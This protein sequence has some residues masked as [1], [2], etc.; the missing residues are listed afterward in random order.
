ME[1]NLARQP[2]LVAIFTLLLLIVVASLCSGSVFESAV[3]PS[4]LGC[5]VDNFQATYPTLSRVFSAAALFVTGLLV[6][7]LT[8]KYGLYAAGSCLAIPL[9]G[10]FVCGLDFG[11]IPLTVCVASL[12]LARSAKNYYSGFRTGNYGFDGFFRASF[13]LGLIPLLYAPALPLMLILPLAIVV[14]KRA[15]REFIVAI[16][17]LLLPLLAVCY[18]TWGFGGSF[19]APLETLLHAFLQQNGSSIFAALAPMSWILFGIL[20]VGVVCSVVFYVRDRYSASTKSRLIFLFNIGVFLL[21][22]S[23]F[24]VSGANAGVAAFAAVP[25]AMLLPITFVRLR[26]LVSS[27]VYAG[28]LL[29]C[30]VYLILH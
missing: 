25:M 29:L 3:I 23:L 17:G 13:D 14:F 8:V 7:R 19:C 11:K 20:L 28:L 30:L 22:I 2:L 6:G 24:F 10:I 18:L 1:L 16:A 12:L 9:Y 5:Y 26:P 21:T 4:L 15:A 27:V